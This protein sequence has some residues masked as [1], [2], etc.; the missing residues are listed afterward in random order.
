M[1]K[2]IT[3]L[4]VLTVSSSAFAWQVVPKISVDIPG[5]Y[6]M[7]EYSG[8]TLFGLSLGGE[9]LQDY[10]KTFVYGAGVQYLLSRKVTSILGYPVTKDVSFG[11]VPVYGTAMLKFSQS[12]RKEL[13][14]YRDNTSS[15]A[16]L[17]LGYN[18][19]YYGNDTFTFSTDTLSGGLYWGAGAGMIIDKRYRV[20]IMYDSYAGTR[21]RNTGETINDTY[22]KISIALGYSFDLGGRRHGGGYHRSR[23][24]AQEEDNYMSW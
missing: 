8:G 5:A 12:R 16:K 14:N 11:Y 6:G 23:E 4:A 20:E 21:Q 1:R 18:M 15:Y 24:A 19:L 9:L 10:S 13:H 3:V 17:N 7:G 22:A 2:I